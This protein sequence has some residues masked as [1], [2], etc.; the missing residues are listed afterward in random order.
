M[1]EYGVPLEEPKNMTQQEVFLNLNKYP[2][3]PQEQ[4]N[5][6]S[7]IQKN[8]KMDTQTEEP[9]AV[10]RQEVKT[11][12][13]SYPQPYSETQYPNEEKYSQSPI[14]EENY[15]TNKQVKEPKLVEQE[16]KTLSSTNLEKEF[17][18]LKEKRR[19]PL[20]KRRIRVLEKRLEDYK[21]NESMYKAQGSNAFTRNFRKTLTRDDK[22]R[23]NLQRKERLSEELRRLRGE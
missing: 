16:P 8:I 1:F 4:P 2:E 18:T 20:T 14:Q 7:P 17:E 9:K 22:L 23:T 11:D 10:T 13:D 15:K 21:D 5:P 3:Q 19:S 12:L 6:N